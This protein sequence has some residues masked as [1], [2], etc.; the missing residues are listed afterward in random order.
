MRQSYLLSRQQNYES[1]WAEQPVLVN[2][3]SYMLVFSTGM[4]SSLIHLH[5][6]ES[7]IKGCSLRHVTNTHFWTPVAQDRRRHSNH[8]RHPTPAHGP[9]RRHGSVASALPA[10]SITEP[11][12]ESAL[13]QI[14]PRSHTQSPIRYPCHKMHSDSRDNDS[15]T[16]LLYCTRR[17]VHTHSHYHSSHAVKMPQT[18]S[19]LHWYKKNGT[20]VYIVTQDNLFRSSWPGAN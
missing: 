4:L 9:R 6:D 10:R 5:S 19:V 14:F 7:C 17:T 12:S 13:H 16:L 18:V 20:I 1:R 15:S 2:K 11:Q 3:H 8:N